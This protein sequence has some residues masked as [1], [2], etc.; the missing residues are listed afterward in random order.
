MVVRV[1][2]VALV[3]QVVAQVGNQGDIFQRFGA[4]AENRLYRVCVRQI[5]LRQ[6]IH[7]HAREGHIHPHAARSQ[8]LVVLRE[9][10]QRIAGE[11]FRVKKHAVGQTRL[12]AGA[13]EG[14]RAEHVEVAV[15]VLIRIGGL[16]ARPAVFEGQ[17]VREAVQQIRHGALVHQ[18]QQVVVVFDTRPQA[19]VVVA[20]V[21]AQHQLLAAG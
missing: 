2:K 8:Q 18:R 10:V 14:Q 19:A 16:V 5:A 12:R 15:A 3:V 9:G 4:L 13:E 20:H 6:R 11:H 17:I 1:V 7:I 21:Q